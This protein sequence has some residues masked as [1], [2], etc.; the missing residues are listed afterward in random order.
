MKGYMVYAWHD[1]YPAVACDQVKGIRLNEDD[2]K[3]LVKELKD[4]KKFDHVD[5]EEI[6][7]I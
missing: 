4:G 2:A 7:I 6:D 1:Y 5:Y 3:A